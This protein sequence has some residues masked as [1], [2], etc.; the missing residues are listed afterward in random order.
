MKRQNFTGFLFAR[1]FGGLFFDAENHE[2]VR[3][4]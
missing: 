4:Q 3:M 2:T 1:T